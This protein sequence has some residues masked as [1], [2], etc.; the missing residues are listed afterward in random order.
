MHIRTYIYTV[1]TVSNLTKAISALGYMNVSGEKVQVEGNY[2]F[3][4]IQR[5]DPP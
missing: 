4:D 1:I 3:L 5:V 2:T